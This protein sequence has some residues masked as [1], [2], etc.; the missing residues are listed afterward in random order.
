MSEVTGAVYL[1]CSNTLPLA[2]AGAGVEKR[3]FMSHAR[4]VHADKTGPDISLS[5]LLWRPTFDSRTLHVEYLT[6]AL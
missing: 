2:H 1:Y 6:D 4:P 3:G 5:R